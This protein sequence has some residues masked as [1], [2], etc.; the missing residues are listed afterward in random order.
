MQQH[1]VA[2]THLPEQLVGIR[3]EDLPVVAGVGA[4]QRPAG[5][6]AV[7]LVVQPLGDR[8][9]L[10]VAA[11]H[12]P[13]NRDVQTRDVPHEHL[14]HLR[15][16]AADRGRID[17]PDGPLAQPV[18]QPG[19]RGDQLHIT[20]GPDDRLQHGNWRCGHSDLVQP[21]GLGCPQPG[22]CLGEAAG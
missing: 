2:R 12:D 3:G 6:L 16:P 22:R 8:E 5:G 13:A 20:L 9:K 15:D 14:Q 11:N 17:V 18:P 19:G 10:R 7:D 4:V 21:P 1:D